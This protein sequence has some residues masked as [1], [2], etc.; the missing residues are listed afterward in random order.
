M[1]SPFRPSDAIASFDSPQYRALFDN[2]LDAMAIVDDQGNFV[3]VNDQTCQLFGLSRADLL[4]C[5]VLSFIASG[6]EKLLQLLKAAPPGKCERSQVQLVVW[7]GQTRLVQYAATASIQP[8]CHLLVLRD[9]TPPS[10]LAAT[11][12][13]SPKQSVAQEFRLVEDVLRL[14]EERYRAVVDTQQEMICRYLPDGT[15]TFVNLPYCRCCNRSIEQLTGENFLD[16]VPEADRETVAGLLAELQTLTPEHPVITHEHAAVLPDGE[17]A[18]QEWINTGIFDDQGHL[19]EIQAVG[20]DISDRK[21]A[22]LALQ[23]SEATNQAIFGAMPDLVIHAHR[24]GTYLKIHKSTGLRLL[25]PDRMQA[26]NNMFDLL[27]PEMAQQRKEYVDRALDT[28]TPQSYEYTVAFADEQRCEEARIVPMSKDTVLLMVRDITERKRAEQALQEQEAQFR[29]FFEQS[30]VGIAYGDHDGH[31]LRVNPAFCEL[32]GYTPEELHSRTYIDLTHPDDVSQEAELIRSLLARKI[33]N[34]TVEKRYL[35]KDGTPVWVSVTAS[36]IWDLAGNLKYGVALAQDISDRKQVEDRLRQSEAKFAVAFQASPDPVTLS[37]LQDGQLL[38]VNESFCRITGFSRE[39]VL[40]RSAVDLQLWPRESDRVAM[41]VALRQAGTLNNYEATFRLKSGELRIGLMSSQIIEVENQLCILSI[42]RD[43]TEAKLAETALRHSEQLFHSAFSDAPIGMALVG[44]DQS[45]IKVNQSLCDMLGYSEAELITKTVP[46]ITHPDFLELEAVYKQA[47]DTGERDSFQMEKGYIHADGHLV[48]G[49]LSVSL[50]RDGAGNPFYYVGHLEDITEQKRAELALRESERQFRAV[51]ET[52]DLIGLMLDREGR[53]TLCND[54]L[55]NLTGWQRN[56]VLHQSWFDRFLPADKYQEVL[57]IFQR[58]ISDGE[59]PPHHENEIVTR[60]GDR[61]QIRWNNTVLLDASGQ[62]VS[63]ACIGEDITE[64]KQAEKALLEERQLFIGGPTIVFRWAPTEGWPVDYVSPNVQAQLGYT[65]EQFTTREILFADLL[66]PDDLY[67]I[68]A[69]VEHYLSSA[70]ICFEQEYRL[71]HADGSYRWLDDFTV[72][73]R[74]EDGSVNYLYGYVQDV[75]DRKRNELALQE[76]ETRYRTLVENIP[77]VVYR[78]LPHEPWTALFLSDGIE[79]VTGYTASD[80]EQDRVRSFLDL[81]HPDDRQRVNRTVTAALAQKQMFMVEYR[82]IHR[83]GEPCWIYERG[84]GYWDDQGNLL[85]LDGVLYDITGR[86][87]AQ[88]AL[89][90]SEERLRLAL[91]GAQMGCWDWNLETNQVVWT[92]SLERI[93]GMAPGSFDGRFDTIR[94]LIYPDDRDRVFGAIQRSLEQDEDYNIEFRFVRPDGNI[95]WAAG[96]GQVIRDQTGQPLRMM[97]IDVDITDR[98]RV[99]EALRTR[100]AQYHL[101]VN[102][103]QVGVW[104]W[105]LETDEIYLD[106]HLKAMLGYADEEIRNH[107]ED[108]GQKVH[109]EDAPAVMQAAQDHLAGLTPEFGIEHR[110]LHKDGSVRWFLARGVAL[111][112]S[113]GEPLRIIGTDTDI[114]KRKHQEE[115]L[116]RYERIVSATPDAVA[117]LDNNYTY[118]VVNRTYTLWFDRSSEEIVGHSSIDLF[119]AEVF[120]QTIKPHLDRALSGEVVHYQEWFEFPNMGRQFI[121]V[122]Y[123]PYYEANGQIIGV[124]VAARNLTNLKRA[125]LALQQQAE[126]E[127]LIASIT[128]RMRRTLSLSTILTTTVM[129]VRRTLRTDRVLIYQLHTPA[130]GTVVAESVGEPWQPLLGLEI[131]DPCLASDTCIQPYLGGKVHNVPNIH[132]DRL[133]DCYKEMLIRHQVQANLV[134]PILQKDHVWGFLVAQ[135]CESPRHW[136]YEEVDLL[137]QLTNQLAIAIQQSELYHRVQ[138]LNTNLESQVQERTAQ[139]QQSL[140][141]EA[142]LKRITD[143]VRD[144]LN[145]QQ[146]LET[147]V[148]ELAHGLDT[149]TCDTG[150]YDLETRTST[151]YCEYIQ[152]N[153]PEAQGMVVKMDD[154]PELYAQLLRGEN[155]QFCRLSNTSNLRQLPESILMLAC[156]IISDQVILGDIWLYRSVDEVFTDQEVHLVQQV[157]NQCAIALRQSRLYQAAQRQVVELERL[158]RLKDDFLSTVSHELRTPMANIQMATQMLDIQLTNLG[159]LNSDAS[160]PLDRYFQVL[161]EECEREIG[162]IN[163]LLDLTRVDS[164]TEPLMPMQIQLRSWVDHI[165]EPFAER[166][167]DHNQDFQLDI[168]EDLCLEVDITYLERI[169]VELFSNACKYSPEEAVITVSAQPIQ[170]QIQIIVTN[171]GVSIVRVECDRIFDKFYRI[172][173]NDPWKYGGT[174]LGLALARHMTEKL[175]GTIRA[176]SSNN[177]V[178]LVLE[179]PKASPLQGEDLAVQGNSSK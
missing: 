52:I 24:D 116:R 31:L 63:V 7:N 111:R 37:R 137:R 4:T 87:Q 147:A 28:G 16:L 12:R 73:V 140:D 162:L 60:S 156:P 20:R 81:I 74:R 62:V 165:S 71:R 86:K 11:V 13:D 49:K 54:F 43:V 2:T 98:K 173:N 70:T 44:L 91:E 114:T 90:A 34:Y 48:W 134:L 130:A 175:G 115:I 59:F 78:T 102:A 14:S 131:A 129:E 122:T 148:L 166:M 46:Q 83:D 103:G 106:P 53:I 107:L 109:P 93:M 179:L 117:L 64:R 135:H 104:N 112:S 29:N 126:Q 157:A 69:E 67:R 150:L 25:Q 172:P 100:E 65:P 121:G 9:I 88:D 26:G 58:T 23:E 76:S 120:A 1:P 40:G 139:L 68:E 32:L 99:E 17:I 142:L 57:A 161:K 56:E 127:F 133:P 177:E 123:A 19:I 164:D 39:E 41:V 143:N 158:N 5:S 8:H 113:E 36:A 82:M 10:S 15:L 84:Q 155:L 51:L 47:L 151:V 94:E 167:A 169:L 119:G 146:I 125:E 105:N 55:L 97:G 124:V 108:W 168:P 110:M 21:R 33:P 171:T 96:R 85:Y 176:E 153:F 178:R 22:E 50:I 149:L 101:A 77:G 128:S 141:F 27:P 92:E 61:R 118:Q 35:R 154:Y 79:A 136:S 18:W 145:E 152:S 163:N 132:T 160:E 138:D 159:I 72:V 66:H 30:A 95:R 3:K 89:N 170:E 45:L 38:E 144:S 75:S 42:I 80:I 6:R 174:G